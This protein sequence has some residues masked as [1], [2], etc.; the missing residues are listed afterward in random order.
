MQILITFRIFQNT[1]RNYISSYKLLMAVIIFKM[2][3][4]IVNPN[5]ENF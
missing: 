3:I 1:K 2:E 4:L 5:Q